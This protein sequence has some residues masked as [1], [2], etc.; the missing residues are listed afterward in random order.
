VQA[1]HEKTDFCFSLKEIPST[2]FHAEF[3]RKYEIEFMRIENMEP[4]ASERPPNPLSLQSSIYS[5]NLA[6]SKSM[7]SVKVDEMMKGDVQD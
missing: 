7:S 6:I 1:I 4:M 2:T 3:R 5:Q